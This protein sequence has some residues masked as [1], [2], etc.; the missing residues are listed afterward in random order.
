M[1]AIGMKRLRSGKL[2]EKQPV[3][4]D[5]P[6]PP[7]RLVGSASVPLKLSA[8]TVSPVKSSQLNWEKFGMDRPETRSQRNT[9]KI[10]LN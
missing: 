1:G 9:A 5:T 7:K 3:V 4:D 8:S 2:G 6:R 10:K